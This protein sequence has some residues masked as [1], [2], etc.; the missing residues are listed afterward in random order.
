MLINLAKMN[1]VQFR[2][3]NVFNDGILIAKLK[4]YVYNMSN[5]IVN[6]GKH[7]INNRSVML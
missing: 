4:F 1:F 7:F 5:N 6:G 3:P 2:K